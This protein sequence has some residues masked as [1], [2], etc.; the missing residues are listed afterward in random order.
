[1]SAATLPTASGSSPQKPPLTFE[2]TKRKRWADLLVTELADV[3]IFILSPTCKV[4]YCGSAVTEL[5]GWRD[6]DLVEYDLLEFIN[7]DDQNTFRTNFED[8]LRSS[9]ELLSYVRLKCSDST[10]S[11]P[12]DVLFEL[13]GYPHFASEHD[14]E[15]GCFFVMAKPYSSRNTALLNTFLELKIEN[16]RLQER[17][18]EL[19]AKVPKPVLP[20]SSPLTTQTNPIY[21]SSSMTT[22]R[23]LP[24]PVVPSQRPLD[25]SGSGSYYP[26]AVAPGFDEIVP[27]PVRT[28]FDTPAYAGGALYGNNVMS[29]NSNT[30]EEIADEGMKKK[31][32]KKSHPSEQYVCI[33]C[34]R[35]DSPEWRKGPLGPKTLCNACGLRWAKQMRKYDDPVEVESGSIAL[36]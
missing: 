12:K 13:K 1:M 6:V 21:S 35:T 36:T 28:T 9:V 4:L 25:S 5:L 22:P 10:P 8:S 11:H 20:S 19:R 33:T 3:L 30:E 24:I 17:V 32:L 23:I 2:F 14:K 7:P 34:G 16:E 26:S 18:L 15:L 31:K 29:A 27:S